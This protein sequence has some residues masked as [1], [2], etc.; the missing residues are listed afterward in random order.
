[1]TKVR[2]PLTFENALTKIAAQIGWAEVARI[3]K[4]AENTVRNWSDQDTT[5]KVS[6][7]SAFLLD[8]AFQ[9]AGG[10]GT[11]FLD[12]YATRV[13]A[14]LFEAT[15]DRRALLAGV[16]SAA[17]ETGQAVAA[18]LHAARP[19]ASTADFIVAE[20][21]VEEA[22]AANRNILATLRRLARSFMGRGS[23][24]GAAEQQR[25]SEVAPID[26]S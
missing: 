21:E 20:R 11:P 10:D 5:A 2:P 15:T 23:G 12:C 1:M 13:E 6:L 25:V 3:C 22:I 26:T 17:R 16:A 7:E 8:V 9:V 4:A 18:S 14:E 19:D 24:N